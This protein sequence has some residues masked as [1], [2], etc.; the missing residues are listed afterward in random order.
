MLRGIDLAIP[1]HRTVGFVGRTG[2]GKSTLIGLILGVLRPTAGRI[3]VDGVTLDA[4][5]L[6]LWQNRIGYVPQDVFL[7]DDSVSANIALGVPAAEIDPAAVERAARIAEIHDVIAALPEGYATRVGERGTRLSGGQRQRLGI[8]RALYH[9]PDVIVFDE[10]TSALDQETEAAV[11]TAIDRL[12]GTRTILM[13]AHRL[14][15]CTGPTS[16]MSWMA[17]GRRLGQ[18]RRGRARSSA[19]PAP[20]R[21]TFDDRQPSRSATAT[22]RPP[23]AGRGRAGVVARRRHR[24]PVERRPGALEPPRALALP[25]SSAPPRTARSRWTAAPTR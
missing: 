1:A 24:V 25:V 22:H 6:P 14:A 8:A 9:D 23:R 21:E 5:T 16:C 4:G 2:S 15:T 7:V 17:A 20:K 19:P 12:A 13:I 3:A 18:H 10:A 11:M